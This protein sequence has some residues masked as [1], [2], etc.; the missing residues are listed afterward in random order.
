MANKLVIFSMKGEGKIAVGAFDSFPASLAEHGSM[1][2]ASVE[3]KKRL[4][5]FLQAG[6]DGLQ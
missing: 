2:T 6:A 4:F 3:E 1:V 5:P